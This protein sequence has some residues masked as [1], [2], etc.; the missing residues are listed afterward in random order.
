MAYQ[1]LRLDRKDQVATITLN[2]PD[3]LNAITPAVVSGINAALDKAQQS[4]ARAV[5]LTRT[6]KV[7]SDVTQES[8]SVEAGAVFRDLAGVPRAVP[9]RLEKSFRMD[10]TDPDGRAV[11]TIARI[12]ADRVEAPRGDKTLRVRFPSPPAAGKTVIEA[13]GL[14]KSYGGPPVFTD[15]TFDLGR[16]ERDDEEGEYLARDVFQKRGEGDEVEVDRV[17]HQL[18]REQDQN[19]VLPGEHAVDA[20]A[21][22]QSREDEEI[23]DGHQS[24]SPVSRRESTVAPI[25]AA[26]SSTARASNGNR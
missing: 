26:S 21:E 6:A 2:R 11:L 17:Q 24:S 8:I 3:A 18:D 10:P 16:G 7:A 9:V 22:E 1:Y 19:D 5:V 12:E 4:D 15:V 20:D 23:S 13:I 25:S 14:T